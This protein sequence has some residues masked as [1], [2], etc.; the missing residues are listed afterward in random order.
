MNT[1]LSLSRETSRSLERILPRLKSS[2]AAEITADP[3]GW[4][5]FTQRLDIHFPALFQL[6][7]SLYG[8]HYDFFFHL[9][10]LIVSLARAWFARPTELRELDSAREL[11]PVWFQS[12]RMLGG[13][14]YVDLFAGNLAGV[15]SKIPYFKELGLTYLHL[16]PLFKMPKGENDGG[17]A[18]SSYREIQP[19]LG[20]MK[21]LASLARELRAVGISLV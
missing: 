1:S 13:V 20:M 2:L 16:M 15:K 18:V 4:K 3:H 14:I 9:E 11:N 21:Q 6:Y 10:D 8:D 17:Y 5:I 12:N 7:F 19:P